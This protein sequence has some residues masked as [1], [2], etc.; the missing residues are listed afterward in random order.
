MEFVEKT[1][2]IGKT[3]FPYIPGFFSF[4]EGEA[5]IRAYKKLNHKPDLLMINACG[6]THPANA[7]FTSHIGVI[8]DKPTI[9]ITKRIFC[10]RAKMPQKEKKPSH[11]I[12]KEHKKVG[13]LKYC[14]KQNQS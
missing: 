10:G 7:G 2:H 6:T 12:M 4:R 13:S 11:C 14:P 8:L 3:S 9:G 5:T 1:I